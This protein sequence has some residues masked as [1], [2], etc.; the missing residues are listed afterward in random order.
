VPTEKQRREAARR[1]LERQLQRRQEREAARQRFT[2]IASIVGTLIVIAIVA[3]VLVMIN[4]D[5]KKDKTASSTSP[6]TTVS[7]ST[8]PTASPTKT[9]PAATGA[10]VTFDGVTVKGAADLKGEPGV[11]IKATGT[12]TKI[13]YKDLVVGTGKAAKTT[14]ALTAQYVGSVYKTGTIFQSSWKL[15]GPVPFTIGPGK[16]IDGFTQGIGGTTGVPP[17]KVGGRRIIIMPAAIAYGA[18]PP[19]GSNIPANADLVFVVDL[20]S[21]TG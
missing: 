6:S 20:V 16:V 2:L 12:P 3:V 17:M 11:T 8:S 10:S 18:S 5:D 4:S 15:G 19:D 1:H 7:P 13:A 21:I 14:S 9:Y